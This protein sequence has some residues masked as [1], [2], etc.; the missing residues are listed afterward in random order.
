VLLPLVVLCREMKKGLKLLTE[1]NT[2]VWTSKQEAEAALKAAADK[3]RAAEVAAANAASTATKAASLTTGPSSA[4]DSWPSGAPGSKK[5]LWWSVSTALGAMFGPKAD[6]YQPLPEFDPEMATGPGT[7]AASAAVWPAA[8]QAAGLGQAGGV[9]QGYGDAASGGGDGGGSS[10][11][12]LGQA[13]SNGHAVSR[14]TQ[15]L[16]QASSTKGFNQVSGPAIS[17]RQQQQQHPSVQSQQQQQQQQGQ[18][19]PQSVSY[20]QFMAEYE[21]RCE[22]VLTKVY[23]SMFKVKEHVQLS[24]S[25]VS[26]VSGRL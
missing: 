12:S 18:P 15:A 9:R 20:Q 21:E 23:Q 25:E 3:A 1:L 8:L 24:E 14:L 5:S 16:Q 6:Q 26:G 13:T 7:A 4:G 11:K 22:A 17:D 19:P 2:L 10:L